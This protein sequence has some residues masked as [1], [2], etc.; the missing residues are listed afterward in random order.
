MLNPWAGEY[1]QLWN[2]SSKRRCTGVE[3]RLGI[4]RMTSIRPSASSLIAKSRLTTAAFSALFKVTSADEWTTL[5]PS[6]QR[7]GCLG[8]RQ[9]WPCRPSISV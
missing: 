7:A 9:R 1:G 3:G 8:H 5:P 4:E 2:L 6:S